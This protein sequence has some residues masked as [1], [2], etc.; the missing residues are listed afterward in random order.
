MALRVRFHRLW[1]PAIT[2]LISILTIGGFVWARA[3]ATD[4]A[5]VEEMVVDLKPEAAK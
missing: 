4:R 1:K 5:P 2:A 3:V